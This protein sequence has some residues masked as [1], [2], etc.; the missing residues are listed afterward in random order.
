MRTLYLFEPFLDP[1]PV[2]SR[3][4]RVPAVKGY[5]LSQ[6]KIT[7]RKDRKFGATEKW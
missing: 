4:A 3:L 7:V 1:L 2:F 6:V 5:T